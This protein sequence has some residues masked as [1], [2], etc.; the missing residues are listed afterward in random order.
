L[1]RFALSPGIG[2]QG[3]GGTAAVLGIPVGGGEIPG[4]DPLQRGAGLVMTVLDLLR[5]YPV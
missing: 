2:D 1:H 3:T 5:Q 4:D